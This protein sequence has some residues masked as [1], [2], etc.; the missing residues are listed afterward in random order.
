[1]RNTVFRHWWLGRSCIFFSWMPTIIT[2]L[3]GILLFLHV[4]VL[5]SVGTILAEIPITEHKGLFA[6]FSH[7]LVE[8]PYASK[9]SCHWRH[10]LCH[11]VW[12]YNDMDDEGGVA[13][14]R[15]LCIYF[16]RSG[17]FNFRSAVIFVSD[18]YVSRGRSIYPM[19]LFTESG[20]G[21]LLGFWNP[22]LRLLERILARDTQRFSFEGLLQG[23]VLPVRL[24]QSE[25]CLQHGRVDEGN[26]GEW[27]HF[28]KPP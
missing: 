14:N 9:V 25:M 8:N 16:P 1:M 19:A 13:W 20:I 27:R 26:R 3:M 15:I 6:D 7:C 18:S 23:P 22:F 11:F 4:V 17:I 10:S 21:P 28:P 12:C 24:L 2:L 5:L